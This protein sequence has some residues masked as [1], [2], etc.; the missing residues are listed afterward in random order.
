MLNEQTL[1]LFQVCMVSQENLWILLWNAKR[2]FSSYVSLNLS[3][4]EGKTKHRQKHLNINH[5][6]FQK[7]QY[8]IHETETSYNFFRANQL[9]SNIKFYLRTRYDVCVKRCDWGILVWVRNCLNRLRIFLWC[10]DVCTW[11]TKS[12]KIYIR[13]MYLRFWTHQYSQYILKDND[14]HQRN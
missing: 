14:T 7:I 13:F 3:I 10:T 8:K 2:I 9:K 6:K 12:G 4:T 11:Q 5:Q 1:K